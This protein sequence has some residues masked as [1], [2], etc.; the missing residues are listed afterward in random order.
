MDKLYDMLEKIRSRP[1]VYLGAES[2]TYL[3]HFI[4]GYHNALLDA[5]CKGYEKLYP[6]PFY[7][8]FPSYSVTMYQETRSI[9][10]ADM[11]L[12][13]SGGKEKNAM[14]H[15]FEVLEEFKENARITG[16]EVCDLDEDNQSFHLTNLRVPRKPICQDGNWSSRP[17]YKDVERLYH[18]S[19]SYNVDLLIP[20]SEDEYVGGTLLYRSEKEDP[21]AVFEGLGKHMKRCFG[22]TEWQE[23]QASDEQLLSLLNDYIF[24]NKHTKG[25]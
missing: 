21:L 23:I 19:F 13:R 4:N 12:E 7:E 24:N 25:I 5:G 6:L 2:I 20:V 11:I 16:C 1:G 10:Y 15:F 9:N 8:L 17:P 3:Y 18:I 14:R 22:Q